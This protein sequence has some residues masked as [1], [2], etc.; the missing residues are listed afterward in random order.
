MRGVD[1]GEFWLILNYLRKKRAGLNEVYF[2]G[3]MEGTI[4]D[5]PRGDRGYGFDRFFIPEGFNV[6]RAEQN[7]EDHKAVYLKIKPIMQLKEFLEK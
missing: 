4:P 5:K 7:D 1:S 3:G 2:E 6:T